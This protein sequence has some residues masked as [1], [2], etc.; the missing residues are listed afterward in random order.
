M[1]DDHGRGSWV[2]S[3]AMET[4]GVSL[5]NHLPFCAGFAGYSL[6]HSKTIANLTQTHQR[7]IGHANSNL[8]LFYLRVSC[9]YK[10]FKRA[11]QCDEY[12]H[13]KL[14]WELFVHVILTEWVTRE[15]EFCIHILIVPSINTPSCKVDDQYIMIF[16]MILLVWAWLLI[17]D[18][19]WFINFTWILHLFV[20]IERI[21]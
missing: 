17:Q 14:V 21:V 19:V 9:V 8:R 3:C 4:L 18:F 2:T 5:I 7:R 11:Y 16:H 20:S 15:N 12:G 13:D 6:Q 1:E 10:Y